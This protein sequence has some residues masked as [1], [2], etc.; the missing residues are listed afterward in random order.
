MSE[1]LSCGFTNDLVSV[2]LSSIAMCFIVA[3]DLG[4]VTHMDSSVLFVF[5]IYLGVA[6]HSG[7]ITNA[8]IADR[9]GIATN[10]VL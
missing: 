7:I 9:S 5:A 6:E 2:D 3:N 10:V 1:D 8:G 4:V